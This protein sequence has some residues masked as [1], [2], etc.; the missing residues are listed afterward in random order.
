MQAL[1]NKPLVRLWGPEFVLIGVVSDLGA[2][3]ERTAWEYVRPEPDEY[4]RTV[5]MPPRRI[6]SALRSGTTSRTIG[7]CT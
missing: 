4:V 1:E 5:S 2:H 3:R 6:I 7:P